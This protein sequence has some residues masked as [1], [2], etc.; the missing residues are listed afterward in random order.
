[1]VGEEE[2]EVEEATTGGLLGTAAGG[3]SAH[4]LVGG[5]KAE[6]V[7]RQA[8]QVGLG[9]PCAWLF[10]RSILV[11]LGTS[12]RTFPWVVV[13]RAAQTRCQRSRGSQR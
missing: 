13:G 5:S 10:L 12:A 7:L 8:V 9:I 4:A 6:G 1:M 11:S 2:E 3:A